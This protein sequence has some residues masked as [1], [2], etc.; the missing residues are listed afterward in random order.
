MK[1]QQVV[2]DQSSS[3]SCECSR[4]KEEA[5]PARTRYSNKGGKERP[6]FSTRRGKQGRGNDETTRILI[7]SHLVKRKYEHRKSPFQH[8]SPSSS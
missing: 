3:S 5:P 2:V 7:S 8:A 1:A 4:Q 6:A